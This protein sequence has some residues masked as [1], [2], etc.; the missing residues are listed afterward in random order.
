MGTGR[1][2]SSSTPT[3]TRGT[4]ASSRCSRTLPARRLAYDAF[5]HFTC[6]ARGARVATPEGERA[7]EALAPGD[8]VIAYDLERSEKTVATVESIVS[9]HAERLVRI[10][11]LLAT[12]NHPVFADG[13]FRPAAEVTE[14]SRLLDASLHELALD[15]AAVEQPTEVFDLSVSAPHTYFAGGLLV[16]NKA[17]AVPI[18]GSAEPF[19]GDFFRRSAK[20]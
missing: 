18:G 15:P 2:G 17:T 10:G 8:A 19:H 14:R 13:R 11:D 7:I 20:H 9:S 3:R 16:H 5:V 1:S 4:P 12:G 6:V